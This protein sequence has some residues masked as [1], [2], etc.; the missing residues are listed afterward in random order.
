[1]RNRYFIQRITVDIAIPNM[2]PDEDRATKPR[3]H[4]QKIRELIEENVLGVSV[5]AINAEPRFVH[6]DGNSIQFGNY[7][8][9]WAVAEHD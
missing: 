9:E 3:D 5:L 1:M 8:R 2:A 7:S 4:R 6:V